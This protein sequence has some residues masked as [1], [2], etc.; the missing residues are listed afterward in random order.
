MDPFIHGAYEEVGFGEEWPGEPES[1]DP[2]PGA[3]WSSMLH[4]EQS[5]PVLKHPE[6][7]NNELGKCNN[8]VD[9]V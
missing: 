7:L 1:W 5:H 6:N 4:G 2:K 3:L 9:K 8:P